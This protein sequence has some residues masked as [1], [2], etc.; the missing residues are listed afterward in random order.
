MAVCDDEAYFKNK[1]RDDLIAWADQY[2]QSVEIEQL[3][4]NVC[5]Q[6]I[7]PG[8]AKAGREIFKCIE[9]VARSEGIVLD[10]VYTGKAFFGMLAEIENGNLYGENILFVHT[11]GI[12]GLM[13]QPAEYQQNRQQ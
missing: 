10:P 8:Y 7:G 13:A 2:K 9:M 6:Y 4:I 12:F 5:D 3:S 11:G 1:V